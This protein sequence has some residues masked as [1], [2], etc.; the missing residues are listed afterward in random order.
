MCN[1]QEIKNIILDSDVISFDIFDTLFFRI[2]NQP[3]DIFVIIEKK[4]KIQDFVNIRINGQRLASLEVNKKY[5]YPHANIDEIY[6]YISRNNETCSGIDWNQIKLYEI[7]LELDCII[8]N[9]EMYKLYKFA[10]DNGK[11]VK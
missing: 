9:E 6:E 4:L 3:E 7:Q 8:Q 1:T 11:R 10:K 2:V 5:Q